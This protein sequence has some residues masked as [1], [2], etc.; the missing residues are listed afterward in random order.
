[1]RD[2]DA[3]LPWL[4]CLVAMSDQFHSLFGTRIDPA[5][6]PLINPSNEL[7]TGAEQE[8][9]RSSSA[10]LTFDLN[11]F[12]GCENHDGI[13]AKNDSRRAWPRRPMKS[14]VS[15]RQCAGTGLAA[16]SISCYDPPPSGGVGRGFRSSAGD[17]DRPSQADGRVLKGDG[18]DDQPACVDTPR[19]L[20]R[21]GWDRAPT[22]L[23]SWPRLYL[24]EPPGD[25][26]ARQDL[27]RGLAKALADARDH[28]RSQDQDCSRPGP[29]ERRSAR[30]R[31]EESSPPSWV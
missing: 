22:A 4:R 20:D 26:R 19:S 15:L 31:G 25:C 24:P 14:R 28:S 29:P 2:R 10:R 12:R 17:A 27:P 1:M 5:S 8:D 9:Y 6:D 30:D 11:G 3:Q 16:N 13:R 23:A 7:A 18:C 21:D